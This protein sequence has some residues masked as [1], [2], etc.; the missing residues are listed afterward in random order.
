MDNNFPLDLEKKLT[1]SPAVLKKYLLYLLSVA[2][3]S[4]QVSL[5]TICFA[6]GFFSLE[7]AAMSRSHEEIYLK[8]YGA[9]F[10][11]ILCSYIIWSWQFIMAMRAAGSY[12][13]QPEWFVWACPFLLPM[14]IIHILF[15]IAAVLFLINMLNF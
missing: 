5:N 14:P 6:I 9:L 13:K 4:F 7:T 11:C 2:V 10:V 15:V 8:M 3:V 12:Q 1:D